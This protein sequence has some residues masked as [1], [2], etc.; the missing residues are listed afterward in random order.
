MHQ[1]AV[2]SMLLVVVG[3][4]AGCSTS[5]RLPT[6]ENLVAEHNAR[7]S[8]LQTLWCEHEGLG[9]WVDKDGKER[10][11]T[12]EG[13]LVLAMPERGALT[14]EKL[15][16]VH[17][18]V[19]CDE[20]RCWYFIAAEERK[21]W[22]A[23]NENLGNPCCEPFP[24]L[25]RPVDLLALVGLGTIRP[26]E[27]E[28]GA[29]PLVA[30]D[31]SRNAWVVITPYRFADLRLYLDIKNRLPVRAEVVDR[32]TGKRI[33]A[34]DLRDYKPL[35]RP[36]GSSLRVRVPTSI[37][38]TSDDVKGKMEIKVRAQSDLPASGKINSDIFRFSA[39]ER[40]M[41]PAVIAVL[42]ERCPR[43]AI[44]RDVGK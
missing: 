20:E 21:A 6:Y 35:R 41:R 38:I 1:H 14:A 2:G 19:G 17:T 32:Q 15:G 37:T 31:S 22:L 33:A 25:V 23:R 28:G 44:D 30:I 8:S 12:F 7:V 36:D 10:F 42:D 29:E 40:T 24:F 34:T 26:A 39:I 9:H 18:W 27:G 5:L 4:E 11:E 16:E 13:V 43:P 3:A